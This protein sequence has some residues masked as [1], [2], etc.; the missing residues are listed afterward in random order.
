MAE[1]NNAN[2]HIAD[3]SPLSSLMN[4]ALVRYGEFSPGTVSGDLTP[5]FLQFA[6]MVI[7]DVRQHPYHDGSDID[8]PKSINEKV[9]AI[10]DMIMTAGLLAHFAVQQGSQKAGAFVPMYQRSL[11]QHLWHRLNGNTKIQMKVVD[12][13]T[14]PRNIAGGKTSNYNGTVSYSDTDSDSSS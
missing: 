8:Y 1:F 4:D 12:D 6:N 3:S 2:P 5:L 10:P 13:G 14:N 7:E 9:P 11:N